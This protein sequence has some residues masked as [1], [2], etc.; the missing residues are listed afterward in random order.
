MSDG[1][2][3]VLL[4]LVW[5]MD[6]GDKYEVLKFKIRVSQLALQHCKYRRLHLDIINQKDTER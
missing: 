1:T 2:H 3:R 6:A 4:L 5:Q